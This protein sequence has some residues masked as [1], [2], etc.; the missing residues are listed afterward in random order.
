MPG[1]ILDVLI[2][3]AVFFDSTFSAGVPAVRGCGLSGGDTC[4]SNQADAS[5]YSHG[6]FQRSAFVPGKALIARSPSDPVELPSRNVAESERSTTAFSI[7]FIVQRAWSELQALFQANS[8]GMLAKVGIVVLVGL[9]ALTALV[10][11]ISCGVSCCGWR[12]QKQSDAD[13]IADELACLEVAREAVIAKLG[14]IDEQLSAVNLESA[15]VEAAE[16]ENADGAAELALS[17]EVANNS[18]SAS[19]PSDDALAIRAASAHLLAQAGDGISALEGMQGSSVL[20]VGAKAEELRVSVTE[21]IQDAR[22]KAEAFAHQTATTTAEALQ[23]ALV[24]DVPQEE[25]AEFRHTIREAV[26]PL[27]GIPVPLLFAGLT[28]PLQLQALCSWSWIMAV[29]QLPA[30]VLLATAAAVDFGMPCGKGELWIWSLGML[31]IS[32]VSLAVRCWVLISARRAMDDVRGHRNPSGS[33]GHTFHDGPHLKDIVEVVSMSSTEYFRPLIAY[34]GISGAWLY[35]MINVLSLLS[36]LWGFSGVAY[37]VLGYIFFLGEEEH[38]EATTMRLTAHVISFGYIAFMLWSVASIACW[39]ILSA[40]ESDTFAM[41][42]LRSATSF[43]EAYSHSSLPVASILLRGTLLR[44][45]RDTMTLESSTLCSDLQKLRQEKAALDAQERALV[46]ELADAEH[47]L[48]ASE[49]R[50]ETQSS[51]ADVAESCSQ[52]IAYAFDGAAIVAMAATSGEAAALAANAQSTL[53]DAG[54]RAVQHAEETVANSRAAELA[55]V[56]MGAAQRSA[57]DFAESAWQQLS[58][59][60]LDPSQARQAMG[61]LVLQA[62]AEAETQGVDVRELAQALA[63]SRTPRSNGVG[64]NGEAVPGG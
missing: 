19:A 18:A 59:A 61:D 64:A 23:E 46:G 11:W 41:S 38:C 12:N 16:V 36:L 54:N 34:D 8:V 7:S 42:V 10:L 33:H 22:A 9:V 30:L 52:K 63:L 47:R 14:T 49:R 28:A 48:Q 6:L 58:N 57:S 35:T 45:A 31:V 27:L 43:D 21:A 4:D 50:M 1:V 44:N 24:A 15:A 32:G 5:E 62:L 17:E 37:M 51:L 53:S 20:D 2:V 26:A 39:V 25:V 40:L 3:S 56:G 60:G 55:E 13:A 29:I